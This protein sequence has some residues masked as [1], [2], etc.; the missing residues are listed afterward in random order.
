MG[1][2]NV[3]VLNRWQNKGD[4]AKYAK[5]DG[6]YAQSNNNIAFGQ[7][8]G[9]YSD[10]SFIRLKNVQL[11]YDL[12]RLVKKKTGLQLLRVYLQ[13]QNLFTI[14]SYVG[15]DPE[16]QNGATLPPLRVLTAGFKLNL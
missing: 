12:T 2:Q 16:N 4:N 5:F 9:I 8:N 7:S 13:A 15:M 11:S 14:T 1:N 3:D 10:A 6:N